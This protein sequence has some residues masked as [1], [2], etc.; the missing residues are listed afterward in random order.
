MEEKKKMNEPQHSNQEKLL[1][2][3][4]SIVNMICFKNI[5]S[6]VTSK[7]L[8]AKCIS[9]TYYFSCNQERRVV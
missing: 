6:N 9:R 4:K 2:V 7:V 5:V 3:L 8:C 1:F